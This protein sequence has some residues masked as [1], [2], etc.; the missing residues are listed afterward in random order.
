MRNIEFA[1][2]PG[3][4]VMAFS[5]VSVFETANAVETGPHYAIRMV[6]ETGGLIRTSSG[7][8]VDT[9]IFEDSPCDTLIVGG[10]IVPTKPTPNFLNFLRRA[11]RRCN[12]VAATCT[13]ALLLAE[14]NVLDGRRATTHW[15]Y[16]GVLQARN[17]S[18]KVDDDSIFIQDGSIWTSA[19]MSAGIDLALALVEQDLGPEVARSVAR[20]LV[21]YHRRA[22]GQTQFSALLELEPKSDRIQKALAYA[23]ENLDT[24]LNVTQLAEAANL[25]PRQFSRAFH[26][27]TGQTP[28]KAVENLRVEAARILMEQSRHP[29]DVVARLT[30]FTDPDRMRRA[31]LR[32]F[33][34]PPQS[35]RRNAKVDSMELH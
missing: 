26:A 33:G 32:V 18:V 28:A 20:K 19:G 22:G 34:Q 29:A 25:S 10:S 2:F 24:P 9:K 17:P 3:Y 31:F 5:M 4:S 27:E 6:S 15:L 8:A 11:P 12:R 13:G 14:A 1:L 7:F 21:V 30:G 23:K 35:I 16:A